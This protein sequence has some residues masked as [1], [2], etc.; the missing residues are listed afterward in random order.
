MANFLVHRDAVKS[1]L[2]IPATSTG[3]HALLDDA[4]QAV[5]EEISEYLGYPVHAHVA[6]RYYTATGSECLYLDHP[7]LSITSLRTDADGDS[8]Y[9]TTWSTGD[10][11]LAPYNATA[12]TPPAPYW[13]IE[14]QENGSNVF[15]V[16]VKRGVAI[17]GTW[18]RW[19]QTKSSTATVAT[20]VNATQTSIELNGATGLHAGQTI[21]VGDEQMFIR[22]INPVSS[23]ATVER[24]VNGTSGATHSSATGIAYYEYP[25]LGRLALYQAGQDYR[26]QAMPEGIAG[27]APFGSRRLAGGVG[28]HPFVQRQLDRLRTPTVA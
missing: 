19:S 5:S 14:V 7:L 1:A 4:I 17:T 28:F 2:G 11:F 16:D 6:T 21:Q 13:E 26:A 25:I 23:A 18:G 10:Y 22:D 8:S 27:D 24:G 9:E 12:Q 20:G 15:P 3:A